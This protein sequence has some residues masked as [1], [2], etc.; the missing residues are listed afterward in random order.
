MPT[1]VRG[2]VSI[3]PAIEQAFRQRMG[4]RFP[5]YGEEIAQAPIGLLFRF[6][7]LIM[8]GIPAEEAKRGLRTLPKGRNPRDHLRI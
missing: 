4:E 7:V 6:A 3:S 2:N 5:Q 8:A 1:L